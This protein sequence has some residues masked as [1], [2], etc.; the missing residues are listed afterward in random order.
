VVRVGVVAGRFLSHGK[1]AGS[2]CE[3]REGIARVAMNG[4]EDVIQRLD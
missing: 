4:R 1:R 3:A 2:G